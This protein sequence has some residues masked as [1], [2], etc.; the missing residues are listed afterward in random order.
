MVGF[1]KFLKH[2][3]HHGVGLLDDLEFLVT[4]ESEG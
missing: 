3:K 1:W 2:P 4:S